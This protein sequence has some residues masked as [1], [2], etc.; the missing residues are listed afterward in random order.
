MAHVKKRKHKQMITGA[1]LLFSAAFPMDAVAIP[2]PIE[3]APTLNLN[4]Q[5]IHQNANELNS[6][7]TTQF[8]S[9]VQ[10][11]E[12]LSTRFASSNTIG[13]FSHDTAEPSHTALITLQTQLGAHQFALDAGLFGDQYLFT[14]AFGGAHE[15]HISPLS[16]DQAFA[17]EKLNNLTGIQLRHR[18]QLSD[19]W[20]LSKSILIG[21]KQQDSEDLTLKDGLDFIFDPANDI[22]FGPHLRTELQDSFQDLHPDIQDYLNEEL[23]ET[24][25]ANLQDFVEDTIV[26]LAQISGEYDTSLSREE[27][28]ALVL[29]S[30]HE[31]SE[32]EPAMLSSLFDILRQG[33]ARSSDYT[34]LMKTELAHISDTS[35]FAIGIEGGKIYADDKTAATEKHASVYL[36][37]HHQLS[38]QFAF[39]YAAQIAGFEN[40]LNLETIDNAIAAGYAAVAWQ[41]E[42]LPELRLHYGQGKSYSAIFGEQIHTEIGLQYQFNIQNGLDLF[43]YA[44]TGEVETQDTVLLDDQDTYRVNNIG[45]HLSYNF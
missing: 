18:T 5:H 22:G 42:S 17:I 33:Q 41:P 21:R 12:H 30:A 44:S 43:G 10:F 24:P 25:D 32:V 38:N 27:F 13:A 14:G 28:T 1:A 3:S 4:L 15:Q 36:K 20:S 19:T 45:M 26:F 7:S 40:Y 39:N 6:S 16:T 35:H 31:Y 2:E 34:L 8:D 23:A 29:Y 11:N 9:H 37:G